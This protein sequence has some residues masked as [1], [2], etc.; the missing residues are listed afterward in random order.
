MAARRSGLL[1]AAGLATRLGISTPKELL[2][3]EGRPVIDWSVEHLLGAGVDRLVLVLRP[4]KEAVA[5]HLA[6]TWPAVEVVVVVQDGA[7]GNLVDALR[8]A[9]PAIAEDEVFLLFP[10][11]KLSPNPFVWRGTTE[12]TLLCHDAGDRW[13][14]FG[15]V[16]PVRRR[17]VEKPASFVGTICWGAAVW[18]PSFTARLATAATLTD[19]INAADWRHAVTIAAYHDIGLAHPASGPPPETALSARD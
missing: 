18:Q 1:P 19:A 9:A 7:I 17:V 15:V 11:T 5:D 2:V 3:H 10:D 16:D 8:A 14:H 12:L 13:P 6:A 4:G